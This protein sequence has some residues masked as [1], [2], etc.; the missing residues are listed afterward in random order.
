MDCAD[1]Y[2]I[3]TSS[4]VAQYKQYYI[5]TFMYIYV[6]VYVYSLHCIEEYCGGTTSH[7]SSIK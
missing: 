5:Y 4:Q 2:Q 6:F 3:N 7:P 1:I